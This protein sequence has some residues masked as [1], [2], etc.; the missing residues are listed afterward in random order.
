MRRWRALLLAATVALATAG[1]PA[2]AQQAMINAGAWAAYKAKFLDATG[3][4]V[5][6][7]NG[8]IS[9]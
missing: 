3:R 8:N 1:P 9:H 5:D 4:I 7:G 2:V 6:N